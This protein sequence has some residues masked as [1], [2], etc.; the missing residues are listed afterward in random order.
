MKAITLF[1]KHLFSNSG[2]ASSRRFITVITSFVILLIALVDLFTDKSVNQFIFDGLMWIVLGGLGL[3]TTEK[4]SPK[5]EP[6]V[7]NDE[8]EKLK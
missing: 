8:L 4:F 7:S 3:L 5:K 2:T 6:P 1:F